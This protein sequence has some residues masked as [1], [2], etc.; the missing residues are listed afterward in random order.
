MGTGLDVPC[1]GRRGRVNGAEEPVPPR[2]PFRSSRGG[3]DTP[4]VKLSRRGCCSASTAEVASLA[5]RLH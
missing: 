1:R 2:L 5:T 3:G 4:T